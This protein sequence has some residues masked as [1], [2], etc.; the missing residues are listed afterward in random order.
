MK[1]IC[2]FIRGEN[3]SVLK[4]EGR[5]LASEVTSFDRGPEAS[6]ITVLHAL[7]IPNKPVSPNLICAF[8]SFQGLFLVSFPVITG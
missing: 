8:S 7:G 3:N 4:G 1:I 2:P 5:R 6:S